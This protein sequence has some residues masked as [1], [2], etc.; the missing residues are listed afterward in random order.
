MRLKA[1]SDTLLG[2]LDVAIAKHDEYAKLLKQSDYFDSAQF[3]FEGLPTPV[4]TSKTDADGKFALSV[5][6]GKYVIAAN[7]SRDVGKDTESYFWL[8]LVDTTSR[9]NQS[10]MLSNDNMFETKCKECVQ[11]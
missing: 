5:P 3:Y 2:L 6:A 9:P 11:P 7:S 8:V 4:G 10:V 1:S